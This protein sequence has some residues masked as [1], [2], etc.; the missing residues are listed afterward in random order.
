MQPS[1]SAELERA[2]RQ[3][4]PARLVRQQRGGRPAGRARARCRA[5]GRPPRPAT[6]GARRARARTPRRRPAAA[7]RAATRGVLSACTTCADPPEE[8]VA[9]VPGAGERVGCGERPLRGRAGE[10]ERPRLVGQRRHRR[11][12]IEHDPVVGRLELVLVDE[13]G[14]Q[15]I[16]A[17]SR[18]G[19]PSRRSPARLP[20]TDGSTRNRPSAAARA[21]GSS[22]CRP[23]GYDGA[24]SARRRAARSPGAETVERRE[25]ARARSTRAGR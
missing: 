13:R 2:E 17:R 7:R 6:S 1:S 3:R 19:S 24:S 23:G 5:S 20:F 15:R 11:V 25:A 8:C 4:G 14:E 9:D 10:R 22:N 16:G 12:G 18:A 21:S